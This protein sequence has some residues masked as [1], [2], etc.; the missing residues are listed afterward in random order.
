MSKPPT[1]DSL[2]EIEVS[3]V[4]SGGLADESGALLL[5]EYATA[6]DGWKRFLRLAGDP[7]L[8]SRG[9]I[10]LPPDLV[11]LE[12]RSTRRGS[13]E[14]VVAVAVGVGIG[15]LSNAAYD[16]L[17]WAVPRLVAW[18]ASLADQH[19]EAKRRTRNVDEVASAL[20]QMARE[21]DVELV[22]APD[23]S[24]QLEFPFDDEGAV[25]DIDEPAVEA[26]E[27]LQG[28]RRIEYADALDH[29]LRDATRP[30][31]NSS[32]RVTVSLDAE[33]PLLSLDR[34]DRDV[35]LQSLTLSPPTQ[36]WR[37]TWIRFVRINRQRGTVT[38]RFA[39]DQDDTPHNYNGRVVDD[40]LQGSGNVYTTAFNDDV[41]LRV[42]IRKALPE[43]GRLN[44]VYEITA[45]G[46]SGRNG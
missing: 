44:P 11:R 7:F 42:L 2:P 22:P 13:F 25:A 18:A 39:A 37:E 8:R 31:T 43:P 20:E 14:L 10:L 28:R 38:F 17:R 23:V 16:G 4:Y 36:D 40:A 27:D 15:I 19:V 9:D 29:A 46:G 1:N 30:L 33:T 32:E 3:I 24:E 41:S 5:D 34:D 35:L 21:N 6:V 26:A 12:I 45:G